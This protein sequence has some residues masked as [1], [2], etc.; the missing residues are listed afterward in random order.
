MSFVK[1]S[2]APLGYRWIFRRWVIDPRTGERRY[3]VNAKAFRFL[4][5][6]NRLN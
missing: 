2:E 4:V 3:P 6:N 5:P 1:H